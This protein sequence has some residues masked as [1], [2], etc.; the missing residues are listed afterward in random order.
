MGDLT[1][2]FRLYNGKDHFY[3]TS[4]SERDSAEKG[5]Y[6]FE[7]IAC[8]V[9]SSQV[10]ATVPLFRLYNGKDHFYTTSESERDSAEKGGYTS[11]GIAC[12]VDSSQVEGTVALYR[13]YNGTDHFYTASESERDSA[14]KGG[15]TSEGIACYAI[16]PALEW[17]YIY[18]DIDY[19]TSVKPATSQD[20]ISSRKISNSSNNTTLVQEVSI[21]GSRTSTFEWGL[22][23]NLTTGITMGFEAGVPFGSVSGEISIELDLGSHQTWTTT[24]DE[25][26]LFSEEVT[27]PPNEAVVLE[28]YVDWTENLITPFT[29][30]MNVMAKGG[31]VSLTGSQVDQLFLLSNPNAT[32]T[33]ILSQQITVTLEGQFTGTYAI[34][35]F[36]KLEPIPIEV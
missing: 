30:T 31:G 25:E 15:Y 34:D 32:V 36:T 27:V 8:Y 3:T 19:N 26:Y 5:G 29:L 7:G 23:Q 17:E 11:E 18:I 28:G 4:E 13:L 6:N 21:S 14:E 10:D 9:D 12:Y 20:L 1:P 24:E 2:L 16:S 35:T 33:Q 22:T